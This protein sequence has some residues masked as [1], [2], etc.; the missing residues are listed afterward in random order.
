VLGHS[1]ESV[2]LARLARHMPALRADLAT[3]DWI[4]I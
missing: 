1:C 4:D 3:G 2:V